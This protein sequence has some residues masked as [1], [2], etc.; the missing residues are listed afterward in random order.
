LRTCLA[1]FALT[2]LTSCVQS[3]RAQQEPLG[4][5]L[6]RELEVTQYRQTDHDLNGDGSTEHIIL[7]TSRYWCGTGGCTLFVIQ[8]TG[9]GFT[10]VSR[11]TIV[12]TPVRLL[13]TETNEW[14]DLEFRA[15]AD[16]FT[17]WRVK[18]TFDGSGYASNPTVPPA[19]RVTDLPGEV[20]LD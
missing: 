1:I 12:N 5:Y 11:T 15:R 20:I 9:E 14:R 6:A 17:S 18:L 13:D 3:A 19:E 7:A 8:A 16:A 2:A 10:L 4:E